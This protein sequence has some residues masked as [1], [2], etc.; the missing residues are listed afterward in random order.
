MKKILSMLLLISIFLTPIAVV[1]DAIDIKAM[2]PEERKNLASGLIMYMMLNEESKEAEEVMELYSYWSG[3]NEEAANR[4]LDNPLKEIKEKEKDISQGFDTPEEAALW[5]LEGLKEL[6][7]GKMLQAYLF[8]K[9]AESDDFSASVRR[10]NT[11]GLS[12]SVPVFPN[13]ADILKGIN[14]YKRINREVTNIQNQIAEYITDGKITNGNTVAI[15]N[16]QRN[17]GVTSFSDVDELQNTFSIEKLEKYKNIKDVQCISCNEA[18]D[19]GYLSENYLNQSSVDNR[20]SRRIADGVEEEKE[21]IVI[22]NMNGVEYIWA[23]TAAKYGDKWGLVS[24][25]SAAIMFLGA[26]VTDVAFGLP[27]PLSHN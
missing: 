17:D 10:I 25:S 12:Y 26:G 11:Y 14:K 21:V 16:L 24:C 6:N 2:T 15:R 4:E 9:Q 19:R 3:Q 20:E 18:I 27:I 7:L 1:A 23:P 13:T 22:Y 8:D 5:Y